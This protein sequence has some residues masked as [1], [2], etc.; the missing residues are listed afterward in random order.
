MRNHQQRLITTIQETLQPLDHL[1]VKMVCWLIQYQE[2]R[3]CNQHVCQSHTFLLTSAQLSHR[4]LQ[5]ADLQLRQYLFGLQHL[6]LFTLMVKT[7]IKHT[8]MRIKNGWLFKHS[9]LQVTT[10][11]NVAMIIALFSWEDRQKRW[12]S[13]TILSYQPY[14]LTFRNREADILKQYQR[15]KRLCQ[16]LNI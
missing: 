11:D 13:C 3:I 7:S 2:I 8:F 1:Q 15:A 16:L 10:E 9:H 14:F 4:L 5:I 6:L 12:L